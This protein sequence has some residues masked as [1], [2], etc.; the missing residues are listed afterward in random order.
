LPQADLEIGEAALG[1]LPVAQIRLQLGIR[2]ES[3]RGAEQPAPRFFDGQS[4]ADDLR[5]LLAR[6]REYFRE[7]HSGAWCLRV[8]D[9]GMYTDRRAHRD[10]NTS[11]AHETSSRPTESVLVL[12]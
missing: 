3:T 7:R 2:L 6:S 12:R 10:G 11:D 1:A 5:R 8:C 4:G 9:A